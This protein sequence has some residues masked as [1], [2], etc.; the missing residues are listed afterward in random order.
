MHCK[1]LSRCS[2]FS[3]GEFRAHPHV[4]RHSNLDL[5]E[6]AARPAANHACQESY[7]TKTDT[8]T[9]LTRRYYCPSGSCRQEQALILEN[10]TIGLV[11]ASVASGEKLTIGTSPDSGESEDRKQALIEGGAEAETETDGQA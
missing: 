9:T 11:G 4:G 5:R 6:I 8:V 10:L 3:Q 7:C 2:S 1:S